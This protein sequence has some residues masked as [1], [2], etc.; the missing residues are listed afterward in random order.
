MLL[1]AHSRVCRQISGAPFLLWCSPRL[2]GVVTFLALLTLIHVS[3]FHDVTALEAAEQIYGFVTNP[4]HGLNKVYIYVDGLL[5]ERR[6]S[7]ALAMEL[8]LSCTNQSMWCIIK[9]CRLLLACNLPPILTTS[10]AWLKQLIDAN[11]VLIF[12]IKPPSAQAHSKRL[13]TGWY[14]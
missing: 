4:V 11:T 12:S 13:L 8:R 10:K 1:S 2:S 5:Q 3:K 9:L 7:S 14:G 6:N